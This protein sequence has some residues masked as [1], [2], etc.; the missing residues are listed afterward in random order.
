MC[1]ASEFLQEMEVAS[2]DACT[3]W[4]FGTREVCQQAVCRTSPHTKLL[5]VSYCRCTELTS[6]NCARDHTLN[7]YLRFGF[8]LMCCCCFS[9]KDFLFVSS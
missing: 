4:H 2:A 8:Y 5:V 6:L 3:A 1:Q 9:D 7:L